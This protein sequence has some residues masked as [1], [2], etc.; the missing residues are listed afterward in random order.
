MTGRSVYTDDSRPEH[1]S[2]KYRVYALRFADGGLVKV[3]VGRP[4]S[5]KT[6]AETFILQHVELMSEKT[7]TMFLVKDIVGIEK[8]PNSNKPDFEVTAD[9]Q[10]LEI[11]S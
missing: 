3:H 2:D 10:L 5:F 7:K 9:G 11:S 1:L 4:I 8:I 6:F